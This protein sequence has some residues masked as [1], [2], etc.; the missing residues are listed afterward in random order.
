MHKLKIVLD[1][2]ILLVSL[3]SKSKYR[4]IFD[5]LISSE[6][7]LFITNEIISEYIEIIGNKTTS[8][9]ALNVIELLLN[10]ENVNKTEVYYKWGLIEVDNDDNKFVDCAIAS[11]ADFI[12]TSDKHFNVLKKIEF[13][14]VKVVSI[15]EFMDFLLKKS[16]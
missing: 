5:S 2:N 4:L 10:L 7:E 8:T 12:V 1:T 3:P 6:F 16:K 15:D 11:N 13:P 14:R 9:I